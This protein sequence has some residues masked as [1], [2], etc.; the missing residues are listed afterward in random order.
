MRMSKHIHLILFLIIVGIWT[1]F[2]F[3]L[4]SKTDGIL[5]SLLHFNYVLYLLAKIGYIAIGFLLA[6][7][8]IR[9]FKRPVI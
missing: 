8:E 5:H 4:F 1:W 7:Y 2:F 6:V 3:E 9:N